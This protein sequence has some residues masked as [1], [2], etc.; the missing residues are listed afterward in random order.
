MSEIEQFDGEDVEG[1]DQ[2]PP[3]FEEAWAPSPEEAAQVRQLTDAQQLAADHP[4]VK[5][6]GTANRLV[7]HAYERAAALGVPELGGDVRFWRSEYEKDPSRFM[8]PVELIKAGGDPNFR[9]SSVLN[10]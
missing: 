2:V 9:G 7:A 1:E 4:A 5:E 6:E 3:G 8:D 10:F